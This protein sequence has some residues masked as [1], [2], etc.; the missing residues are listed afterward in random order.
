MSQSLAELRQDY[1][2]NVLTKAMW[3]LIRSGNFSA[4]C[5]KPSPRIARAQRH[6]FGHRR[7]DWTPYARVVL[8]RVR[9][10]RFRIL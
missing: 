6:D 3:T 8:L 1:S 2:L 9:C 5:G 7:S 4:G 10:R